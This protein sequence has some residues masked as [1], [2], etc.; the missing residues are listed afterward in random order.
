MSTEIK[1]A[2]KPQLLILAGPNGSGKTTMYQRLAAQDSALACLPFVNADIIA[3][4]LAVE[5]GYANV[6]ELPP[7]L[8]AAVDIRAGKQAITQRQE[9]LAGAKSFITETTA[10]SRLL[11]K[12]I[13]S[14]QAQG[15]AV[16]LKFVLLRSPEHNMARIKRR[17]AQGGHHVPDAVVRRRYA[18][19][20]ALLPALLAAADNGELWDN[21]AEEQ[22]ACLVLRHQGTVVETFADKSTWLEASKLK[23]LAQACAQ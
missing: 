18:K 23:E 1:A 8:K 3:Q 4:Q 10:S 14:A 16:T 11:L 17:V 5:Q 13:A 20:V 15:Y 12:L 22:E 21:E 7:A 6:N 9:L 2:L 19:A